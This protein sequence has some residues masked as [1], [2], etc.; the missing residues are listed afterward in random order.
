MIVVN[1]FPK[2]QTVPKNENPIRVVE[3]LERKIPFAKSQP[4]CREFITERTELLI[5]GSYVKNIIR[6]QE[7]RVCAPFLQERGR[8]GRAVPGKDF[9]FEIKKGALQKSDAE[10]Q[11]G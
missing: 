2:S 7:M 6:N 4:V 3:F 5:G 1:G 9:L 11:S 10:D 8:G